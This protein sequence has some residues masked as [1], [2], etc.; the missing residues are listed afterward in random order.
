MKDIFLL[1]TLNSSITTLIL[2]AVYGVMRDEIE[3]SKILR[4]IMNTMV[5]VS[6]FASV[7]G[8]IIFINIVVAG[9]I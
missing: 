2:S 3:R 4:P 8:F 7:I 9:L 1:T 6:F 5:G